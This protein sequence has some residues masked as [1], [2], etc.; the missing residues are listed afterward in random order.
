MYP[1]FE[2]DIFRLLNPDPV[3]VLR[4]SNYDEITFL[5]LIVK[6]LL[7]DNKGRNLFL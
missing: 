2:G 7:V 5:H 3:L 6:K 1:D 4:V